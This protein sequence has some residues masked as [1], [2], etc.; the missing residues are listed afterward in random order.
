MHIVLLLQFGR[1]VSNCHPCLES[2]LEPCVASI[3][4]G[5]KERPLHVLLKVLNSFSND[6]KM[7]QV[8]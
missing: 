8:I 4:E 1:N 5:A 3:L 7:S 2:I 6:I